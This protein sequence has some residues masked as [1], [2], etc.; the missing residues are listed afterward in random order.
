MRLELS[1]ANV[2]PSLTSMVSA[3]LP[4][5][6]RTCPMPA[7][8]ITLTCAP[9]STSAP[10]AKAGSPPATSTNRVPGATAAPATNSPV[11]VSPTSPSVTAVTKN[12]LVAFSASAHASVTVIVASVLLWTVRSCP[13]P[14]PAMTVILLPTRAPDVSPPPLTERVTAPTATGPAATPLASV[15]FCTSTEWV[16]NPAPTPSISSV[17]SALKTIGCG[18]NQLVASNTRKTASGSRN[19]SSDT[20]TPSAETNSTP[21]G[22][23]ARTSTVAPFS[24]ARVRTTL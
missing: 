8:L 15:W 12:A 1:R 17:S 10:A 20:S 11:I 24:G 5:I 16:M 19:G 4:T 7:P 3:S 2:Q 22:A 23:N 13:A 21:R 14:L 18:T 6:S 9:R